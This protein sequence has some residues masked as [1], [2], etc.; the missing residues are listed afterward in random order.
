MVKTEGPYNIAGCLGCFCKCM[1]TVCACCCLTPKEGAKTSSFC[2]LSP[3][4]PN[5]S[6]CY[7]DDCQVEELLPRASNSEDAEKLWLMSAKLV[8]L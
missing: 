7:F 6:G 2:A 4:I 8:K 5:Y 1:W 3:D